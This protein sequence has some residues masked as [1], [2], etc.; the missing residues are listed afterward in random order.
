MVLY[1]WICIEVSDEHGT[2][3]L[4]RKPGDA[5]AKCVQG[6]VLGICSIGAVVKDGIVQ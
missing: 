6:A 4:I 5:V 2:F 3:T 1:G